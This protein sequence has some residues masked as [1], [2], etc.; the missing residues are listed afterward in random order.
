MTVGL[1]TIEFHLPDAR[2]L[3]AKRMV[4]SRI[5]GRLRSRHNVAVAELDFQDKWQRAAL[6]VVSI[7]S[8]RQ[9]VER[10]LDAV[11]RELEDHLLPGPVLQAE[12]F[13]MEYFHENYTPAEKAAQL[14]FD[15][16]IWKADAD[17]SAALDQICSDIEVFMSRD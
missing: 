12:D 16:Q 2:S 7:G 11:G 17:V 14:V 13:R 3:K 4:V 10:T 1:L 8:S 6:G 5:K 9:V 15:G